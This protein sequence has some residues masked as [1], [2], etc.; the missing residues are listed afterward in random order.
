MENLFFQHNLYNSNRKNHEYAYP[1]IIRDP[2]DYLKSYG[3][4]IASVS[5]K[6][7]IKCGAANWNIS[8]KYENFL[9]GIFL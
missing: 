1:A 4:S 6:P 3:I 9:E 8:I 5:K 2:F 7:K